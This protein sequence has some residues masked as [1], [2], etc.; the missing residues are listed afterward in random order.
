MHDKGRWDQRAQHANG[1]NRRRFLKGSSV[2]AVAL[3]SGPLSLLTSRPSAAQAQN[4]TLEALMPD[5]AVPLQ[6]LGAEARPLEERML[7]TLKEVDVQTI[8]GVEKEMSFAQGTRKSVRSIVW[9]CATNRGNR[10]T[11]GGSPFR[12]RYLAWSTSNISWQAGLGWPIFSTYCPAHDYDYRMRYRDAYRFQIVPEFADFYWLGCGPS[13]QAQGSQA[14]DVWVW[15]N[16]FPNTYG[17]N[18]GTFDFMVTG[19]SL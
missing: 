8:E 19:W 1:V 14:T 7:R 3:A 6:N 18:A 9:T 17:D 10:L 13:A 4:K 11:Y 15:V 5:P 12:A 2:A 16:D